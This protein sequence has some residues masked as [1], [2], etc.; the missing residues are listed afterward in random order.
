MNKGRTNNPAGRPRGTPNK[1]TTE[2]REW[3]A[4][5]IDDNRQQLE[6][7]LRAL[8]PHQRWQVIE[9][10]MQYTTPK[11]QSGEAKINLDQ[12]T[13]TQLDTVINELSKNIE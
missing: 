8:E 7:D 10:L 5:L 11:M 12:L 13:D 2:L 4:K 1:V 9:R 3:I 6:Q